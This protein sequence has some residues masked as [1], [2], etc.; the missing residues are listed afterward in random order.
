MSETLEDEAWMKIPHLT[1][2][3]LENILLIPKMNSRSLQASDRK[4][5]AK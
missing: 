3:A 2:E 5:K 1:R 4:K